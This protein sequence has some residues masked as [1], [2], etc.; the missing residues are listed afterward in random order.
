MSFCLVCV[1]SVKNK[2]F[3]YFNAPYSRGTVG[4]LSHPWA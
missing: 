2:L 4:V 3:S 1:L